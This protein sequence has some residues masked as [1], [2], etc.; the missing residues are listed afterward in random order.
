MEAVLKLVSIEKCPPYRDE[1][2]TQSEVVIAA[3]F[4]VQTVVRRRNDLFENSTLSVTTQC[5]QITTQT[6]TNR[7]I[8]NV[9]RV[10]CLG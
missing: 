5:I 7:P 1:V 9:P 8:T 4:P 10:H 2:K 3:K 6:V